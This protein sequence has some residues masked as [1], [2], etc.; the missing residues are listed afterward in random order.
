MR[1]KLTMFT[2]LLAGLLGAACGDDQSDG[3]P[4]G[5]V[6]STSGATGG[7]GGAGASGG[8][9]GATSSSTTGG[10][11]GGGGGIIVE[12][13]T[14]VDPSDL[15]AWRQGMAIGEWKHLP[16]AALTE[17]TPAVQPGGGYYGR[18]DAWNGFAADTVNSR[19]YLGAAGGHMDYAGNEVYVLDLTV[20][21]PQWELTMEPSPA[22]EYTVDQPYYL[23]GRP[24]PTHTYYTAWFIEQRGKF[25]RFA[26]AATWGSGNGSTPH[27][28]SWDP[29]T[30]EWDPAGTN[31]DMGPAPIFEMPVAKDVLTGEVY[32]LQGN[33]RLYRWDPQTNSTSDLGEVEG[34]S[35]SFYDV[36]ASASVVDV[37]G[38][39]VIFF[40]DDENPGSARIY[41]IASGTFTTAPLGGPG[42]AAVADA[43]AM[44]WFDVC[45]AMIVVKTTT[46]G[47]VFFVDPSTL[48]AS[49]LPVSGATLPDPLNGVHTLFQ[50]VPR[51]GGYAYQPTHDAGMYFLATQ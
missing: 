27:I 2:G 6:T 42:A 16:S 14:C 44:A 25:F 47:E 46:G 23:D 4:G 22:S 8:S 10:S 50:Y 9:G 7:S 1:T 34:G 29:A 11:G 18:I 48:V 31:P 33:N 5:S 26:G 45:A 37:Q 20:A 30:S 49:P 17:V 24:S 36:E 19:I 39:R 12:P 21:A 28:D 3:T 32:Q 40:L 35:G 13:P 41:D 51:L 38:G 43:Q 15:P